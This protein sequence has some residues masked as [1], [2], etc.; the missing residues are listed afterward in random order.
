MR[1]AHLLS[2][3]PCSIGLDT[4]LGK[5]SNV[6]KISFY[7]REPLFGSKSL[8]NTTDPSNVSPRNVFR[9]TSIF[10]LN[11]NEPNR[12]TSNVCNAV[13]SYETYLPKRTRE[14]IRRRG[15]KKKMVGGGGGR[16]KIARA[17]V[18]STNTRPKRG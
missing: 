17:T 13:S 15:R 7:L 2:F 11:S 1:S 3:D 9:P 16:E 6:R 8:L 12:N 18:R 5:A 14:K 4:T 10:H